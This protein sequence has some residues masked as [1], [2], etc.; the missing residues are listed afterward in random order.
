SGLKPGQAQRSIPACAGLTDRSRHRHQATPVHPGVRGA[1]PNPD[2]EKTHPTGPSPRARGLQHTTCNDPG[3][4]LLATCLEGRL[5]PRSP[6]GRAHSHHETS[7]AQTPGVLVPH[8][9]EHTWPRWCTA[10]LNDKDGKTLPPRCGLTWWCVPASH[11][12]V[13]TYGTQDGGPR[14][15]PPWTPRAAPRTEHPTGSSARRGK[16][17]TTRSR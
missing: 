6:G 11:H 4:Y 16:P 10:P 5:A 1:Y 3:R 15:H 7:C 9:P 17:P 14:A 12:H 2:K 13:R 8:S